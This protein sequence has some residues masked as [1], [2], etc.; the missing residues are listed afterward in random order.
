MV[1]PLAVAHHAVA[2]AEPRPN[3]DVLV[4]GAGLIGAAV[5]LFARLAGARNVVAIDT[6]AAQ[7]EG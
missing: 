3:D 4:I 2:L 1:E 5:A 6:T 7:R